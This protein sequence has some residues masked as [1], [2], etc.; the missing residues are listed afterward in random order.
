MFQVVGLMVALAVSGSA[1]DMVSIKMCADKDYDA[2]KRECA[3]GKALEG[4]GI[5]IAPEGK[6]MNVLTGIKT[7]KAEDIYHVWVFGGKAS[8][9]QV[10]VYDSTTKTM[11]TADQADLEWLKER[12]IEGARVIVKLSVMPSAN[13]RTRSQKTLDLKAAGPWKVQV[14]DS[15]SLT[16]IGEISF[17]V[18]PKDTGITEE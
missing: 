7:G 10:S 6:A 5:V 4:T 18:T 17:T 8:N 2:S 9:P 12:K 15:A 11:R 14:Y 3:S 13:F 1:A 16:P